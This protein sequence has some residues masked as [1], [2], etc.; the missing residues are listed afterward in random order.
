LIRESSDLIKIVGGRELGSLLEVSK[1]RPPLDPSDKARALVRAFRRKLLKEFS[2]GLREKR[3][4]TSYDIFHD[5]SIASYTLRYEV[6]CDYLE[7]V[8]PCDCAEAAES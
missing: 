3:T 5:R 7:Y 2:K 6:H 1:V 4:G 8:N